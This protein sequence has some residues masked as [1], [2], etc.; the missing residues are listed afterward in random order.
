MRENT[1]D[2]RF[3]Y[4]LRIIFVL[5]VIRTIWGMFFPG[6]KNMTT[7]G[8]AGLAITNYIQDTYNP[9][10][11]GIKGHVAMWKVSEVKERSK[12]IFQL[13]ENKEEPPVLS[14]EYKIVILYKADSATPDIEAE[15]HTIRKK[16]ILDRSTKQSIVV[17]E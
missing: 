15:T 1:G 16:L 10:E 4:I 2:F 12:N 9:Q 5:W 13:L 3:K 11:F 8:G 6:W 14:D 7:I 17:R